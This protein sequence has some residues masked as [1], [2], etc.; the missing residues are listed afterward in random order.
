MQEGSVGE[1]QHRQPLFP[2]KSCF[3]LSADRPTSYADQV[4]QLNVIFDVI[5]TPTEEDVA[6]IGNVGDYLKKLLTK[7]SKDLS[8]LY[9]AAGKDAIDLLSKMLQFNPSKRC[10]VEDAIKHEVRLDK[11]RS[12]ELTPQSQAAKTTHTPTSVK[13]PTSVTTA[14]ILIPHPNPFR[15]SLRSSQFFD[16]FRNTPNYKKPKVPDEEISMD[17]LEKEDFTIQKLKEHIFKEAQDWKK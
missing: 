2:G 3:P 8:T 16:T 13:P 7:K 12:D 17:F 15:D 5:G 11:E 9:K 4:D 6:S 1:Y 14:L 10:T